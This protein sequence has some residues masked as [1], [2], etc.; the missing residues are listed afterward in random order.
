MNAQNR[1][2]L[3]LRIVALASRTPLTT[4]DI[5]PPTMTTWPLSIAISLPPPIAIPTLAFASAG[6]SLIPSPTI[7]TFA[8]SLIS[9]SITSPFCSGNTLAITSPIPALWAIC[10][11]DFWLSPLKSTTRIPRLFSSS[12]DSLVSSLRVSATPSTPTA[13]PSM[14]TAIMLLP[15]IEYSSAFASIS[16]AFTPLLRK[17]AILPHSTRLPWTSPSRPYPDKTLTSAR[18]SLGAILSIIALAIGCSLTLSTALTIA[19]VCSSSPKIYL[20]VNIGRPVV[21][22][23]VLSSTIVFILPSLSRLSAFLNKMPP[24]APL[25]IPVIIAVGV[26]RPNAHGQAITST[27]TNIFIDIAKPFV[28]HHIMP[29]SIAILITAGTN[30]PDTLSAIL[31]IGAFEFC[32]S[33][34]RAIIFDNFVASPTLSAINLIMPFPLTVPPKTLSPTLLSTGILSPVNILSLTLLSPSIII[35]SQQKLSPALTN[36]LSPFFTSALSICVH[37]PLRKTVA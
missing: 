15:C 18:K 23:P 6:A 17:S 37:S 25:P 36:T 22:V 32:A 26:A 20:S 29:A 3:I 33:S 4:P 21:M 11:A 24:F 7:A 35:P 16:C 12:I 1:F 14:A 10:S 31:A 34:T 27:L 8:P 9:L 19:S 5:W 13:L 30:T 28:A 2:C